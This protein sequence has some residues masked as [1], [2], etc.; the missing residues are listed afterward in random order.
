MQSYSGVAHM[1]MRV[2]GKAPLYQVCRVA[3]HSPMLDPRRQCRLDRIVSC[4]CTQNL[5]TH[6]SQ[7]HDAGPYASWQATCTTP[8][9]CSEKSYQSGPTFD[10]SSTLAD[11][12][13]QRRDIL[14]EAYPQVADAAW[15]L[16]IYL[17]CPAE[18][19]SQDSA[20]HV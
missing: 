3:D 2:C 6:N 5:L 9:T 4:C 1:H 7:L 10:N 14:S 16:S 8:D 18:M 19:L 13:K 12:P 17:R 20:R 11:V 15:L